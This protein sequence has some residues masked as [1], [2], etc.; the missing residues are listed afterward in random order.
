MY[1]GEVYAVGLWDAVVAIYA[2]RSVLEANDIRIPTL[3]EPWT[4]EEFDAIL[5]TLQATGEFENAFDVGMA[6]KGEW[7]TY[8]FS[9]FLQSFGG[10]MIDRETYLGAEGVL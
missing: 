2:R 8:A 5:E 1:N 9:P 6:W 3:E 7:Y 10:D 4:G